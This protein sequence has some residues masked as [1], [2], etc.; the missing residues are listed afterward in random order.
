MT[1]FA[2][3]VAEESLLDRIGV[4]ELARQSEALGGVDVRAL[5]KALMTGRLPVN[6]EAIRSALRRLL[7]GLRRALT[8]A[9]SLLAAPVLASLVLRAISDGDDHG[10]QLV[11][12]MGCAALL[13][14]RFIEAR[15]VAAGALNASSKLID[16]AAP[17]LAT[18]LTLT[19]SAGKA[20]ILT[21]SAALC[22]KLTADVLNRIGLPLCG[23]IAIVAAAANLSERFR[24]DRLFSL[25]T[26][27]ANGSVGLLLAGFVGLMALQ[28][29]LVSGQDALTA[30]ALR[31][32]IHAALP[33]IGGEVSDSAGALLGSAIAARNAVGVAGMLA[34]MGVC[35][36]PLAKLALSSLSLRL[37]AAALEP[38]A[39]PGVTRVAGAFA[40]VHRLLL[41]ISAGGMLMSVL[42]L[43]ACL[44]MAG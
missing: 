18:A 44:A 22:A 40:E 39:D 9:L 29:L 1:A 5:C 25:L 14:E 3:G 20:A 38:I 8:E 26:R 32:A 17:A 43:G 21:P 27:W 15:S 33:V 2:A 37:A 31:R 19:G 16:A 4:D 12:R 30:R 10:I 34:A 42:C 6:G 35:A 36:A 11:C 23:V 24:L 13:S 28:G 41:A 7:K